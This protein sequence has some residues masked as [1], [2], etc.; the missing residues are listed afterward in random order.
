MVNQGLVTVMCRGQVAMKLIAG[1]NGDRAQE[2]ASKLE[3]CWPTTIL[4]AFKL[5]SQIGFGSKHD[6][7]VV[8]PDAIRAEHPERLSVLYFQTLA[9]PHFNPRWEKGTAD[10]FIK[11]EVES[12]ADRA[13]GM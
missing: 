1:S 2:L 12:P 11:I 3:A 10:H 4:S 13:L 9:D 7:V 5:A 6:L 8:T